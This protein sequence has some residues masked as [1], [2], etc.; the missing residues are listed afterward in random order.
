MLLSR[1][2]RVK[3][4]QRAARR[5]GHIS[6]PQALIFPSPTVSLDACTG[7][8]CCAPPKIVQS[9]ARSD[10]SIGNVCIDASTLP[11]DFVYIIMSLCLS[12]ANPH[13]TCVLQ[14]LGDKKCPFSLKSHQRGNL[15][16]GFRT[17][18]RVHLKYFFLAVW[19]KWLFSFSL[20][21][22][23]CLHNSAYGRTAKGSQECIKYCAFI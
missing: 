11:M 19:G 3:P 7:A 22:E 2:L 20:D 12:P 23:M 21:V 13:Q 18:N 17:P 8:D 14:G 15:N 9:L 4:S 1:R 10:L 16:T 6:R 5:E